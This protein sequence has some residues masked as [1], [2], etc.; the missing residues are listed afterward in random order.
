MRRIYYVSFFWTVRISW[1]RLEGPTSCDRA[2]SAELFVASSPPDWSMGLQVL[3][4]RITS[5]IDLSATYE[6]GEVI[7]SSSLL[8]S[9]RPPPFSSF[10]ASFTWNQFTGRLRLQSRFS[11]HLISYISKFWDLPLNPTVHWTDVEIDVAASRALP[12]VFLAVSLNGHKLPFDD[13]YFEYQPCLRYSGEFRATDELTILRS[14][15]FIVTSFDEVTTRSTSGITID[16]VVEFLVYRYTSNAWQIGYSMTTFHVEQNITGTGKIRPKWSI[17]WTAFICIWRKEGRWGCSK[18]WNFL[19]GTW[20][21]HSSFP[22][23][24]HIMLWNITGLVVIRE[25]LKYITYE[26]NV[27]RNLQSEFRL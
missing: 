11:C 9:S 23:S 25:L 2:A 26:F 3:L 10:T 27:S 24:I 4:L 13:S 22:S 16:Y 1:I 17:T 8:L 15:K 6:V 19:R 21:A 12:I 5:Q 20:P 18:S 7:F 14:K